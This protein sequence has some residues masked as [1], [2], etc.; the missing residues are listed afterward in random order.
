MSIIPKVGRDRKLYRIYTS[1]IKYRPIFWP[2]Y[3][4]GHTSPYWTGFFHFNTNECEFHYGWLIVTLTFH[5]F[6]SGTCFVLQIHLYLFIRSCINYSATL[7]ESATS[8]SST[9]AVQPT[10]PRAA[11]VVALNPVPVASTSSTGSRGLNRHHSTASRRANNKRL[12]ITT[13]SG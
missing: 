7:A 13:P 10:D 11:A 2:Y 3:T 5:A 1:Y 6:I 4:G 9:A 8:V 12:R